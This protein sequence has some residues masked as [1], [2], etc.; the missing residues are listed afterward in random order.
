M[1]R[2]IR[3]GARGRYSMLSCDHLSG[4]RWIVR[5]DFHYFHDSGLI[6]VPKGFITDFDSV[7]RLPVVYLMAKNWATKSALV[8]DY[9]YKQGRLNGKKISRKQ[10]DFIFHDAMGHEHLLPRRQNIIFAGVRVGGWRAWGKH[11]KAEA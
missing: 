3:K 4:D 11:R 6:V 9:L 8:H 7:P 5:R 1:S 2:N 10:A